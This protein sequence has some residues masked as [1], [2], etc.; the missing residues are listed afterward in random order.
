MFWHVINE[1]S[2]SAEKKRIMYDT[3]SGGRFFFCFVLSSPSFFFLMLESFPWLQ[4]TFRSP[5]TA[6]LF[7]ILLVPSSSQLFEFFSSSFAFLGITASIAVRYRFGGHSF[8]VKRQGEKV[9]K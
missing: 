2:S 9:Q 6:W 7:F 8:L 1:R 3:M 5:H 4:F